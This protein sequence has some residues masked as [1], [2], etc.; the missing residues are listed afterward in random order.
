MWR[1]RSR[2][3]D[4]RIQIGALDGVRLDC[5]MQHAS[6]A[7]DSRLARAFEC[8]AAALERAARRM[9]P[10]APDK[11]EDLVQETFLRYLEASRRR[12]CDEPSLPLL[13]WLLR[14]RALDE[15]DACRRQPEPRSL[16]ADEPLMRSRAIGPVHATL[17][18]ERLE[19]LVRHAAALPA[20]Q[21]TAL[22][23]RELA[24]MSH[25]QL[26]GELGTTASAVKALIHRARTNL[27]R[28]CAPHA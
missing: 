26:A 5:G 17:L 19:D 8:H 27:R 2:S 3:E 9:L 18:R 24:G 7:T 23:Q 20:G 21:R 12:A 6:A 16:E 11:A 1:M 22:L 25:E 4:F 10:A 28:A 15:V 14:R 13:L